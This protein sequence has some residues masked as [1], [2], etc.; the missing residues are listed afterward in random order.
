MK[1]SVVSPTQKPKKVPG[2][3]GF[4]KGSVRELLRQC[5]WFLLSFF[6]S[7]TSI[8]F[9]IT[10]LGGSAFLAMGGGFS[11][12]LGGILGSYTVGKWDNCYSLVT[13]FLLKQ[14]FREERWDPGVLFVSQAMVQS[15][16]LLQSPPTPH[17][18]ILTAVSL[19]ISL[20]GYYILKKAIRA[21]FVKSSSLRLTRQEGY[22]SVF[23]AVALI[24]GIRSEHLIWLV[25]LHD[26]LKIYAVCM[27]AC[28]FGIGGG[29]AAG[30][31]LGMLSGQRMEYA[32]LSMSIYSLFG[33]FAGLFAGFSKFTSFLGLLFSYVFAA[34]YFQSVP[35]LVSFWD[36][37]LGGLLFLVTPKKWV[38]TY[39]ERYHRI[40]PDR[41]HIGTLNAITANRLDKLAKSFSG[42]STQLSR[43]QKHLGKVTKVS[44]NTLFDFVG[45][46][47]CRHCTL[48]NV[49]W[50]EKYS[51]TADALTKGVGHLSRYGQL[52]EKNLL[53]NF[54]A[55][56]VRTD[57]I[58]AVCKN[59]YE[60][61]RLN[62]VWKH[63]LSENTNAFKEQFVELSKIIC[64]LKQNI[65]SNRYFD[66]E[67][68]SELYSALGNYGYEVRDAAVIHTVSDRY[69]IKLELSPCK[70][71][72]NCFATL[73]KI[74]GDVVGVPVCREEGRCGEHLCR[75][76]FGEGEAGHLEQRIQ[77]ISK[78][79]NDPVGDS[80]LISRISRNRYLMALS[81]GM[82]SGKEASEIST[83]VVTLLDEMLKAG[84]S[85]EAAY[86]MLNAFLIAS[87]GGVCFSTLDFALI[88][89][90]RMTAKL[91][92]TGACPTYL[93]RGD[94]IIEIGD[95][96]LPSGIRSGTPFMKT[97]HLRENDILILLSDG[98]MD[99]LP[100]EDW[101][102]SVL[103]KNRDIDLCTTVDLIASVAQKD[104]EERNDD[105]TVMGVRVLPPKH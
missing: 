18:I 70:H 90:K 38:L 28:Y 77:S 101:V 14:L 3:K 104:F 48:R 32:A 54:R 13:A 27:A 34:V 2:H 69:L 55:H 11:P 97:V 92:K 82:G 12:L 22:T 80:H 84:F 33:F 74:I 87:Y 91:I 99:A 83:S 15:I 20:A 36:V 59:F 89:L 23:L 103:Q 26:I 71:R 52:E 1:L 42:L 21:Q 51:D 75:L 60:L 105:I 53:A 17:Q 8:F 66:A 6:L 39:L 9:D 61:Y 30:A 79:D 24:C 64:T 7:R 63:K 37:A 19:L 88:D 94:E 16:L 46:R 102:Y 31:V 73:E 41:E 76:L 57:K 4:P 45:E 98:V 25:S 44:E 95:R 85:P 65:E 62:A 86:K 68:S 56:C 67:L 47:V 49:C 81:D 40:S 35:N 78:R 100:E 50:Q 29:S 72:E 93:K 43:T 5:L 58:V 10:P 96:S